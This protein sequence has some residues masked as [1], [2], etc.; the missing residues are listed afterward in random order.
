MLILHLL[1]NN[2]PNVYYLKVGLKLLRIM[3][4]DAQLSATGAH[5]RAY[6]EQWHILP[7]IK[8]CLK[9]NDETNAQKKKII[10]ISR[11]DSVEL[12]KGGGA[13]GGGQQ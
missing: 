8:T 3:S 12:G 10:M 7:K 5:E 1:F 4:Q 2:K 13:G 11:K 6:N 9:Y